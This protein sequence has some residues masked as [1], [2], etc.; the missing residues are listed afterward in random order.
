MP[1]KRLSNVDLPQPLG[2]LTNRCSP[3]AI[4]KWAISKVGELAPGQ[5]NTTS[6]NSIT[7]EVGS[8]R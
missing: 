6:F 7:D 1:V 2:P 4:C 5:Q 8:E 3:R